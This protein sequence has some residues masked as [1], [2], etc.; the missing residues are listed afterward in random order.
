MNKDL[1]QIISAYTNNEWIN[2]NK[3][4]VIW[5]NVW[6]SIPTGERLPMINVI[7]RY[8]NNKYSDVG[9]DDADREFIRSINDLILSEPPDQAINFMVDNVKGV[10]EVVLNGNVSITVD[11]TDITIN[12]DNI[13]EIDSII[14]LAV[15]ITT[16]IKYSVTTEE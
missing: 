12:G 5:N 7:T 15:L 14:A 3:L 4:G 13:K 11:D 10:I 9:L 8:M 2:A 1:E 6:N 16:K